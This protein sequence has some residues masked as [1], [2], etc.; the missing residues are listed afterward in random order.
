MSPTEKL[1]DHAH[2]LHTLE[3]YYSLHVSAMTTEALHSKSDIAAELAWRDRQLEDK[4]LALDLAI[5][6]AAALRSCLLAM[7]PPTDPETMNADYARAL[8]AARVTLHNTS[9]LEGK[10]V[11]P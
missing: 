10:G 7:M 5:A 3:P 6:M 1:Y 8:K 11:E 9:V 4:Q 2:N